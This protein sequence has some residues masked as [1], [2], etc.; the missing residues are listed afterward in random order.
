MKQMISIREFR[1]ELA[2]VLDGKK[3]ILL[4]SHG[5]AKAMVYPLEDGAEVPIG[6]KRD[7]FRILAQQIS[8]KTADINEDEMLREFEAWRKQRRR[9]RR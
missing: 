8:T 4:T 7:A 5:R 9:S 2:D 3:P 6:V 1:G